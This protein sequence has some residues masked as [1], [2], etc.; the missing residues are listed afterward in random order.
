MPCREYHKAL[1]IARLLKSLK[2]FVFI[3]ERKR[4]LLAH[5]P[6]SATARA[7]PGRSQEPR[8]LSGS[9]TWVAEAQALEPSFQR[10]TDE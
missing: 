7:G 5:S 8:T 3:R 6:N 1:E 9:S 4:S 10:D 2:N